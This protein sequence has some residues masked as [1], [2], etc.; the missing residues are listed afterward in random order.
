MAYRGRYQLGQ[1]VELTLACRDASD[2]PAVPTNVPRLKV[3]TPAGA[4][5]R[6]QDLPPL[7]RYTQ[8]G[9][10]HARLIL[11]STFTAGLYRVTYYWSVGS[12]RGLDED[13]F[14]VMPGGDADGAVVALHWFSRPQAKFLVQS[15]DS[16]KLVQ[17]RNPTV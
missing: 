7:E 12:F 3:W 15:L 14:E 5:L 2:T 17:G 4:L 8:T 6:F 13:G 10:F 11:D 9:L 1:A 16:G